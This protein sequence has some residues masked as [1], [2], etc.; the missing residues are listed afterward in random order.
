MGKKGAKDASYTKKNDFNKK[1]GEVVWRTAE[2]AMT[3]EKTPKHQT[4][5]YWEILWQFEAFFRSVKKRSDRSP[6]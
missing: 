2:Y 4:N 3:P 5:I 6:R 1:Q